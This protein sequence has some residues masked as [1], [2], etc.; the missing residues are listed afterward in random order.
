MSTPAGT[1]RRPVRRADCPECGAWNIALTLDGVV[2]RHRDY[3]TGEW[4]QGWIDNR[5]PEEKT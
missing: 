1:G 5:R 3:R 2:W 4:C